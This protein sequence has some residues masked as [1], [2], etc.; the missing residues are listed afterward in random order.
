LEGELV[1]PQQFL[2]ETN[3]LVLLFWLFAR[4]SHWL[5]KQSFFKTRS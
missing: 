5:P 2:N 3:E 4:L 1:T